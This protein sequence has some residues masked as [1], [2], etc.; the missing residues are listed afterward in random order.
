MAFYRCSG[1]AS[2]SGSVRSE[3]FWAFQIRIRICWTEVQIRGSG[4]RLRIRTKMSRIHNTDGK[5]YWSFPLTRVLGYNYGIG[6]VFKYVRVL[7]TYCTKIL[8]KQ[9]ELLDLLHHMEQ[10]VFQRHK[11]QED[12][13]TGGPKKSWTLGIQCRTQTKPKRFCSFIDEGTHV[14]K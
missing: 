9:L 8:Q 5:R 4:I 6:R 12:R 3:C 2:G 1:S 7:A 10:L 14:F 13:I 11:G